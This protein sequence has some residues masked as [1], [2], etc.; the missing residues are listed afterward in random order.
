[1]YDAASLSNFFMD[2]YKKPCHSM[3]PALYLVYSSLQC[4]LYA[5]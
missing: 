1:M 2:G 5:D 3:V 4:S